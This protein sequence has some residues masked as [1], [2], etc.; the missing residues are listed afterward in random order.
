MGHLV[1]L[2]W[3][4]WCPIYLSAKDQINKK[5]PCYLQWTMSAWIKLLLWFISQHCDCSHPFSLTSFCGK[6]PKLW[7]W[8]RYGTEVS[9]SNRS[10]GSLELCCKCPWWLPC[11]GDP[12]WSK[13]FLVLSVAVYQS[14]TLQARFAGLHR[15]LFTYLFQKEVKYMYSF[16]PCSCYPTREM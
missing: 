3:C 15:A 8:G 2:P 1:C 4:P 13:P 9:D 11:P 16:K 10:R 14:W 12:E 7:V 6:L 5:F